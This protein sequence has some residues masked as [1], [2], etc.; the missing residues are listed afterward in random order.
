MSETLQRIRAGAPI[1][2]DHLAGGF[3]RQQEFY[4]ALFGWTFED[5]GE[6]YGQYRLIRAGD[7]T[8]GGAM[9]AELMPP[10]PD[11]TPAEGPAV[12]SVYLRS[13]DVDRTLRLVREH[14]GTVHMEPMDV[15]DLGRMAVV[16]TP[17]G[18]YVGFWQPGAFGGHDLPLTPGT[19]V[20]FEVMSKDFAA[21]AA[22]YRAV[23]GWDVVPLGAD[24]TPDDDAGTGGGG[25]PAYATDRAGEEASAGLC[26]AAA[27]LPEDVPSH[28]R[29]YLRTA[30]MASSV[31]TVEE[32]GGRV[33]DGPADSPFGVV[34]TV[35]D[36]AGA[37]FQLIQTPEG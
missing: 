12:W 35:L 16:V 2:I 5:Q 21:D 22:F 27:W 18:E 7:A 25:T 34:A 28:W 31:R 8:V 6:E 13:D 37:T 32:H 17:G 9:D 4:E 19:S 33:V 26:D 11:G 36:P 3:A 24:G 1:W 15:G 14:G 23:C 20:W 29:V 30:D 10:G